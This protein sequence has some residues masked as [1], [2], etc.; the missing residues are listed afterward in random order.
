MAYLSDVAM[1]AADTSRT[2]LYFETMI[3]SHLLPSFVLV[4]KNLDG[5]LF[6]GQL[7]AKGDTLGSLEGVLERA[8]VSYLQASSSDVNHPDVINMISL[9]SESVFIYSGF[10]GVL[11]GKQLLLTGKRFLHIHGGYLPD[12]KGSTT[13][14][15][16]LLEEDRMGASAIFLTEKIDCGPIIR[17]KRV[18]PPD[19]REQIDHVADAEL[20]AE[21]LIETLRYFR[22]TGE[23]GYSLDNN[24]GETYYVIH[25]LLKHIAILAGLTGKIR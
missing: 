3:E 12:Y 22:R 6:P 19:N 20:R 18:L 9:R 5:P 17:R 1:I 13:N 8:S 4:L 21:V 23:W 11:V 15:F 14:Y 16:S 10:G 7:A 2:R 24:G 25:P